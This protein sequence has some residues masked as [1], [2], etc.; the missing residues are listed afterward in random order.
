MKSTSLK[1]LEAL[2]WIMV[3][4][5]AARRAS[6][7]QTWLHAA[8]I[9][10]WINALKKGAQAPIN[11]R[12]IALCLEGAAFGSAARL[13][14]K[15]AIASETGSQ[16]VHF[17]NISCLRN[18]HPG[19][20]SPFTC[21]LHDPNRC[22]R[23]H[24][25]LLIDENGQGYPCYGYWH[26]NRSG[27]GGFQIPVK[28]TLI[29]AYESG[30]FRSLCDDC[31]HA[32]RDGALHVFPCS[33]LGSHVKPWVW[34]EN[35]PYSHI[36]FGG[37]GTWCSGY[38]P[39]FERTLERSRYLLEKI[40]TSGNPPFWRTALIE[41]ERKLSDFWPVEKD[42]KGKELTL[43]PI[44]GEFAFGLDTPTNLE[45]FPTI[46][47]LPDELGQLEH[48][49]TVF[50]PACFIPPLRYL[51]LNHQ[52]VHL[53][54][55]ILT[56][57]HRDSEFNYRSV[58][59][60]LSPC[61][62]A[63]GRNGRSNRWMDVWRL[64]DEPPAKGVSAHKDVASPQRAQ[65]KN[66]RATASRTLRF[67]SWRDVTLNLSSCVLD[68][69]NKRPIEYIALFKSE[70]CTDH[71]LLGENKPLL[72]F[73]GLIAHI[74]SLFA[75]NLDAQGCLFSSRSTMLNANPSIAADGMML[76]GQS[77]LSDGILMEIWDFCFGK[78]AGKGSLQSRE[79]FAN[80]HY[81]PG[82]RTEFV[83]CTKAATTDD[84]LLIGSMVANY[85][86]WVFAAFG[87][88][89]VSSVESF[90]ATAFSHK[91]PSQ[92]VVFSNAPLDSTARARFKLTLASLLQPI[93]NAYA[94]YTEAQ[95]E[96]KAVLHTAFRHSGHLLRNRIGGI[97]E[98]FD[99]QE[100]DW[101][102][103]F[104]KQP[105]GLKANMNGLSHNEREYHKAWVAVKSIS[106]TCLVLQLWGFPT[107]ADFWF[108][109]KNSPEKK[110]RF[111]E[112]SG[113]AF[114]LLAHI[115]NWASMP[116]ENRPLSYPANVDATVG[117]DHD[118]FLNLTIAGI[119][120]AII[121]PILYDPQRRSCC[122][123]GDEVLQ[124]IFW[125]IFMNAV[126]HGW[127]ES[128]NP[129]L[130]HAVVN[131]SV[132]TLDIA[133]RNW[134]VLVNYCGKQARSTNG[135]QRVAAD[136]GSGLGMAAGMLRNLK[137]GD[138][139]E[140]SRPA[141]DGKQIFAVAIHLEGLDLSSVGGHV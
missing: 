138:I 17:T 104:R 15:R 127:A 91:E 5:I 77:Q 121:H 22:A 36:Q 90:N 42:G 131:L 86:I 26:A 102:R 115:P 53:V 118:I 48:I 136:S 65:E 106:D 141:G 62:S 89:N 85:I 95:N 132:Q 14:I 6:A 137:L 129:S 107:L 94:I 72:D 49:K 125:E 40:L 74:N 3:P 82:D 140:L 12:I 28:P 139:I 96:R 18:V 51:F 19:L 80:I 101:H 47:T 135:W 93:E 35:F 133:H 9:S 25:L 108:G 98:F 55:V 63:A 30:H 61:F 79:A 31:A 110:D 112:Y 100:S 56:D 10:N 123:L 13:R 134:L 21:D 97:E 73:A 60:N 16:D 1:P 124:A 43:L 119:D 54:S 4:E 99:T 34:T 37:E 27:I 68:K 109:W 75:S 117:H 7:L 44:F 29:E 11:I 38:E 113:G 45:N 116:F 58:Y 52:S 81:K 8:T 67:L 84:K 122:R 69:E 88:Q 20:Q 24:R 59:R 130:R 120:H 50:L 87:K 83:S 128:T 32:H 46:N 114:D 70:D 39:I 33:R 66:D 111:F 71:R 103:V 78:A 92:F 76:P 126:K 105:A 41:E 23:V 57:R 64:P 2:V